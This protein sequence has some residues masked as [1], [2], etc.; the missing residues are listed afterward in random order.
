M[1]RNIRHF[2]PREC[3]TACLVELVGDEFKSID[4]SKKLPSSSDYSLK[5][6]LAAGV[7][8]QPVDPTIVH[9]SSVTSAVTD[10][11]VNQPV[12]PFEPVDNTNA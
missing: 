5:H 7:K 9:D 4:L 11:L 10:A 3:S 12:E 2:I 1:F 8:V 6:M